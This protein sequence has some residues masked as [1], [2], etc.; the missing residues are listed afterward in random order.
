MIEDRDY[1]K[2][3]TGKDL[4]PVHQEDEVGPE[5]AA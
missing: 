4:Q 3:G 1:K 2:K 5:K